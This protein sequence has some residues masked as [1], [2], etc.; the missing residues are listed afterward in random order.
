MSLSAH[1]EWGWAVIPTR[2]RVWSSFLGLGHLTDGGLG[3]GGALL[4]AGCSPAP[5]FA[6]GDVWLLLSIAAVAIIEIRSW[7]HIRQRLRALESSRRSDQR[8]VAKV[9]RGLETIRGQHREYRALS[10]V[11]F[12]RSRACPKCGGLVM[13]VGTGG[14]WDCLHCLT[15]SHLGDVA[16]PVKGLAADGG[17]Q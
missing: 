4:L 6:A 1:P 14:D 17:G 13:L 16:I 15:S 8:E 5:A 11:R 3:V 2:R 10:A 7:R 12:D 9:E